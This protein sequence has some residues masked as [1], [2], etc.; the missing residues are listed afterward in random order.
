VLASA[1]AAATATT[2]ATAAMA[3]TVGD[4]M[5]GGAMTPQRKGRA[6][7]TDGVRRG[8]VVGR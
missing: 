1:A 8:E 2:I 4:V 7:A 5:R 6:D 3:A